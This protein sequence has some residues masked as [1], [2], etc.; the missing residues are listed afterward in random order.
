MKKV[1]GIKNCNT[2]KNALDWLK[3]NN[4]EYEFHDYKK[5][6]ITEAKLKSWSKQV[7]W[8]SLVNKRGTT[9]RQ[10]DEATQA[11][12]KSE[13]AAI[14]LMKDKT[15]VI[16]RPLIEDGDSVVTLGFDEEAFKKAYK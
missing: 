9:W 3:K 10:L 13:S 6:G 15:S 16:K 2:V 7:G 1:Y 4:V 11:K 8:E 14:A 5:D 12:V